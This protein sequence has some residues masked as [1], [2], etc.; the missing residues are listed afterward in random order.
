MADLISKKQLKLIVDALEF[1]AYIE[2]GHSQKPHLFSKEDTEEWA[3]AQ[4]LR[5][6]YD[7]HDSLNARR[8]RASNLG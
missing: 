7:I 6:T 8:T 2:A 5:Q 4:G 3:L 1:K